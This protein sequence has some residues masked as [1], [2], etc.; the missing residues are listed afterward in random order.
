MSLTNSPPSPPFHPPAFHAEL[1]GLRNALLDWEIVVD[2][3][4]QAVEVSCSKLK[5]SLVERDRVVVRL[6][7]L[8]GQF[9]AGRP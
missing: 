2:E 7:A 1:E 9:A 5:A 3:D 4:R 6:A 8:V